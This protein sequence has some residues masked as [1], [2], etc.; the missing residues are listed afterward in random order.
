M[1]YELKFL[2]DEAVAGPIA[3]WTRLHLQAD[4]HGGGAHGDEYH[5]TTLY[6][7]TADYRVL[8]QQGSFARAKYRVRRYGS[9]DTAFL[10]RKM[11]RARRVAKRRTAVGLDRLHWLLG[12]DQAPAMW[13]GHWF[14][15]RL[16]LRRLQ[17][18]C[19]LSYERIARY[20]ERVEGARLTIDRNLAV[21]PTA[22]PLFKGGEGTPVL[23]GR[24]IVELKYRDAAPAVFKELL[25][26]F[27]IVPVPTSKYRHAMSALGR[28]VVSVS[29]PRPEGS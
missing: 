4:P 12:V 22:L 20:S 19:Q 27:S 16:R 13:P 18:A 6:W 26:A 24:C 5:T 2:V 28:T 11:R 29:A 25:A 15:R 7:D 8:G 9:S 1:T 17:P 14:S 3:A 21:I 23:P 10:E